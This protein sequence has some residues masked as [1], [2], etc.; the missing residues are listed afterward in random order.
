M[1]DTLVPGAYIALPLYVVARGH[2]GAVTLHAEYDLIPGRYADHVRPA[3]VHILI[4][5]AGMKST[6]GFHSAV[7]SQG[8]GVVLAHIHH[9]H[10]RPF[11]EQVRPPGDLQDGKLVI[12]GERIVTI[13]SNGKHAQSFNR[14]NCRAGH[15]SARDLS[16]WKKA[17]Y[18]SST[19]R[20]NSAVSAVRSNFSAFP[21]ESFLASERMR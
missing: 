2:H 19:A 6:A 17:M 21:K 4:Y 5:H 7:V 1:A 9:N 10:I 18:S 3:S 8:D 15:F 16:L 14:K 13:I 11:D 20:Q 12:M